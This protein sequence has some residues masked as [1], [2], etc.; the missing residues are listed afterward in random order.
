MSVITE[1]IGS[2][3]NDQTLPPS[4]TLQESQIIALPH[5]I[6]TL[7]ITEHLD[8]VTALSSLSMTCHLLNDHC[9]PQVFRTVVVSKSHTAQGKVNHP[10]MELVQPVAILRQS[11]DIAELIQDLRVF[12]S[13]L[14]HTLRNGLH[15]DD[16]QNLSFLFTRPM[17]SLRRLDL[18]LHLQWNGIAKSV[19]DSY[20]KVF[21]LP[22]LR[23]VHLD[24][25]G[26]P[27]SYLAHLPS[28]L[29]ILGIRGS[30]RHPA[31]DGEDE[32]NPPNTVEPRHVTVQAERL[33][34][35]IID[36]LGH[37]SSPVRF[38][39]L[40]SFEYYGHGGDLNVVSD[41]VGR[42]GSLSVTRLRLAV[43]AWSLGTT[44]FPLRDRIHIM[45]SVFNSAGLL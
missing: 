22:N 26:V 10:S 36:A 8:D 44:R 42:Q 33:Y 16:G 24:T 9:R 21:S 13:G 18:T 35:D 25:L 3:C 6:I 39:S 32:E 30:I 37:F 4:N 19:Q 43:N 28:N 14:T 27:T 11:P 17:R 34:L 38:T 15:V 29:G 2:P 20:R 40:Q 7:L 41:V 12:K 31:E 45:L 1:D 5:D 23:E